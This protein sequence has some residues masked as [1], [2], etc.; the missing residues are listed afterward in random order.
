MPRAGLAGPAPRIGVGPAHH[1]EPGPDC[2]PAAP[3][4][5][6]LSFGLAI[7]YHSGIF[8]PS[9]PSGPIWVGRGRCQKISSKSAAPLAV[10][11]MPRR[12]VAPGARGRASNA[13]NRALGAFGTGLGCDCMQSPQEH[14]VPPLS[15]RMGATHAR[16][17]LAAAE[18][19][20]RMPAHMRAKPI[21]AASG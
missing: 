9:H 3:L 8:F 12:A 20:K 2:G 10:L 11:S 21:R 19:C 5:I 4:L 16:A 13:K 17:R 15:C 6:D 14:L 18:Q 7:T 1:I